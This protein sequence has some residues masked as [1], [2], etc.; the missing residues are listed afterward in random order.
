MSSS[1][2][3]ELVEQFLANSA[4]E[5]CAVLLAI[6]YLVLAVRED[7]RCWY[8]AF[9]S[10][11]IFL[12]IFWDVNLYMESALQIYYLLMAVFGWYQWREGG[13]DHAAGLPISRWNKQTHIFTISAVIAIS[14]VSGYLLSENTNAKLPYLDS[15]T[16]WASVITTYMVTRKIYENWAYWLVIDAVSIYLYFNRA[17]YFTS[18]LFIVYIIIIGFGWYSW[19]QKLANQSNSA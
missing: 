11:G 7:V 4:L 18:L 16:T 15:F 8:A 19:S 2:S 17:L 10:T 1:F 9:A 3:H 13:N 5:L 6:I 12:V 14:V